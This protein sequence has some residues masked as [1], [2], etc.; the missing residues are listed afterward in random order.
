MI[1][2]GFVTLTEVQL[3]LK[4]QEGIG[5]DWMS[6]T[7]DDCCEWCYNW[8]ANDTGDNGDTFDAD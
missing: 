1:F 7:W 6:S 4:A 5:N 3:E 8:E 2:V